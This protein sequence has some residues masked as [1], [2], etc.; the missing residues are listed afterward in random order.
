MTDAELAAIEGQ[1]RL[2]LSVGFDERAQALIDLLA[3]VRRL[4]RMQNDDGSTHW[5]LCW[6]EGGPRHWAC[7]V[8]VVE[9]LLEGNARLVVALQAAQERVRVLE[10]ALR[11]AKAHVDEME[12]AWARGVISEHDGKGGTRSNRNVAVARALRAALEAKVV[13][14]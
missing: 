8:T 3:E 10:E 4:R 5:P 11:D 7:A 12:E 13:A 9:Q 1:A 2:M 6:K 14:S